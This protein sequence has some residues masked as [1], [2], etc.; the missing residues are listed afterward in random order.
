[1]IPLR[2]FGNAPFLAYGIQLLPLTPVSE[3]R[4]S[5]QWIR[6][7]YPTFVESCDSDTVCEREGWSI[8]LFAV[9]AEL[10]H[11][12]LAMEKA[13][14][15]S[16]D[17]FESAGGSG[18]SLTN[19]LWYISSRPSPSVPFN[20]TDPT[21]SIHSKSVPIVEQEKKIDC[22][23]PD[24]C[25]SEVLSSKADGFTCK[26]RIQWLITN[27]GFSELGACNVVAFEEYESSCGAC[28]PELCAG[29]AE[30]TSDE[31]GQQPSTSDCPPCT[32]D[33]CKSD[34]NR[35]QVSTAPFLCYEGEAKGGCSPIPWTDEVHCS[36]CCELFKGCEN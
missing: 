8:L 34:I 21:S 31:E 11:Q 25:T 29:V 1:M 14:A 36:A 33:V 23:C 20:L 2:W 32:V 9:L 24:T 5:D 15:L 26:E 13:L 16:D 10:G 17:V 30:K 3:R 28:N 6:Q 4:D 35:C 27:K 22:G 12:N 7:L 18:H 19:T